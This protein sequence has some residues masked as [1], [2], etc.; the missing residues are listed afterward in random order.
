[1]NRAPSPPASRLARWSQRLAPA[2]EALATA[3]RQRTPR[4]RRLLSALAC[5]ALAA[6]AWTAV[7]RPALRALENAR[8]QLPALQAQAAQIDSLI[9]EAQALR[10]RS[11]GQIASQDIAPALRAGL[12]GAGLASFAEIRATDTPDHWELAFEQ[13]PAA[14]VFDW[15]AGAPSVLRLQVQH[16]SLAR[17]E[18][19][20]RQ[21]P[22]HVSG[23]LRLRRAEGAAP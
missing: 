21:R 1:M 4:E 11:A 10:G 14:R 3:W 22:G 17:A 20:G 18:R 2:G 19:D 13:A 23:V 5:L 6:L 7:A 16:L 12:Q 8:T 15:L 9:L